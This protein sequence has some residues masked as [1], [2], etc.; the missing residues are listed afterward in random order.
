MRQL[1]MIAALL[2]MLG[3][4]V[5]AGRGQSGALGIR[6]TV[7]FRFAVGSATFSSGQYRVFSSLDKLWIQDANGRTV[8]VSLCLPVEGRV[9]EKNGRI[10]FD[11]YLAECFLS[12]V[13]IVGQEAGR[14]LPK[15]K[16]ETLLGRTGS[17]QQFVLLGASSQRVRNLAMVAEDRATGN[18]PSQ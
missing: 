14:E 11:C 9:P 15:S 7:P 10:V 16:R 6:V 5:A 4:L 2:L 3:F 1:R 8:A 17:G 18:N 12:Q 13:W